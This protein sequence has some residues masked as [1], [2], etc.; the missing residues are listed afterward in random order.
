M[1][2]KNST[3]ARIFAS[4][5]VA[6]ALLVVPAGVAAAATTPSLTA[7]M[8]AQNDPTPP[9]LDPPV[10]TTTT[11]PPETTTEPT[12]SQSPTEPPTTSNPGGDPTGANIIL[13]PRASHAGR[14][15]TVQVG[16]TCEKTAPT[17]EAFSSV[18]GGDAAAGSEYF[19]AKIKSDIQ[20]GTYTVSATCAG[21][22]L[23]ASLTVLGAQPEPTATQTPSTGQVAVV[24]QGPAET[25]DGS[26]ADQGSA[27]A[28]V[29]VGVLAVL[30]GV[31]IGGYTLLRRRR[32]SEHTDN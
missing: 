6:G 26:T 7:T 31:G 15:I 13:H 11:A 2:R 1:K 17:S 28:P 20:P 8:A 23:S 29:A 9:T 3:V 22:A 25:G 14:T 27:A 16:G 19:N 30:S 10:T 32:A 12:D 4:T 21:K 24:P 5:V 18:T